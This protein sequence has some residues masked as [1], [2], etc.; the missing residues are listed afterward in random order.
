[1]KLRTMLVWLLSGY[2]LFNYSSVFAGEKYVLDPD[3]SFVAWQISHFGFSTPTGKWFA[4]GTINLDEQNPQNSE[5][6]VEIKVANIVTG[7]PKL[8]AHLRT[9]D[10]FDVSKYPTATFTSDLVTLTG[11][12][13]ADVLG[14][15]TI[16]GVSKPVTLHVKLNKHDV[17]PASDQMTVGFTANAEIKRSEFGITTYLPGLGDEVKLSIEAE[18]IRNA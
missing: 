18:G 11:K 3:H 1:M 2:S 7:L 17:S 9:S 4:K 14:I 10:F 13:T 8:D 16:H 12:N 15:L 5:V 6:T